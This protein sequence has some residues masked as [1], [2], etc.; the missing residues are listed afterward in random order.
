MYNFFTSELVPKNFK[1]IVWG[2][3][4]RDGFC[5]ALFEDIGGNKAK[6]LA[7]QGLCGCTVLIVA[8]RTGVYM[9]HYFENMAFDPDQIW[10][11]EWNTPEECFNA[12]VIQG[13]TNGVP[14]APRARRPRQVSL[15]SNAAAI[16]AGAGP[17]G[18]KVKGYL[19]YPSGSSDGEATTY[20]GYQE[21]FLEIKKTVGEIIPPLAILDDGTSNPLWTDIPYDALNNDDEALGNTAAGKLIFKY[22]PSHVGQKKAALWVESDLTDRHNDQ[23]T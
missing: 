23:W 21:K 10:L 18:D 3:N 19:I 9:A 15:T 6:S 17:D 13:L 2:D 12:N 4:T 7:A 16:L 5:T 20:A 1:P 8:S 14:A 11:D 22:D